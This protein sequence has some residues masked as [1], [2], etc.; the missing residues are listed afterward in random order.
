M[1]VPLGGIPLADHAA[2]YAALDDAGFT[3]VWS[4][5][6]AGADAFTPLAL[7][8]AWSPRLRL[9]TAI[10]PV[11]TR[12]PGLLAMSAAALAEAAPGRFA[13]GVG[14]SSPVLVRDWNAIAF[15]EPF[16][17]TRDVLRFLRAALRGETVDGAFDT[18]AVRRFTLERPPSVPP[19]VV[20]AAL[21]PGML[22]LAAA[23]ADGVILNWLAADDVPTALAE[24]GERRPGFDVAARIFVCPTEDAAYARALGRRMITGY[25]TV[26]AYAAFHRWLGRED[27]LGPMWEAWAAGD[28]RGASAAVPDE[29]VDALVLHG[30]PEQ[31]VASVR[32]YADNGVDVP[33][34]AVLPTPEITEGG[35]AAWM[36]LLPRL[37]PGKVA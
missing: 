6:V 2:V 22:R 15:D 31:C 4:S 37:G 20:L 23:E 18:F 3:D 26:P 34:I 28:R 8:A 13:L 7:A 1:T 25:L 10:T 32:R 9:G 11:F 19:P 29:V 36:D 5:E 16:K 17:R 21:R 27:S 30:S 14:S 35:A 33:V 24:V 12:G